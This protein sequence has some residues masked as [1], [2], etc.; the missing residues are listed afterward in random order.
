ME[1]SACISC[2]S[3]SEAD[4]SDLILDKPDDDKASEGKRHVLRGYI[5]ALLQMALASTVVV[6]A[7]LL[8]GL[9]PIFQMTAWRHG[10]QMLA[11]FLYMCTDWKNSEF[12]AE[13]KRILP[14]AGC[15]LGQVIMPRY[16]RSSLF[17]S[18]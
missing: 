14:I 7:Q 6:S 12:W 16:C 9:V 15:V 13:K 2:C 1:V 3:S 5:A 10:A 8:G 11:V 18:V 4:E 17:G